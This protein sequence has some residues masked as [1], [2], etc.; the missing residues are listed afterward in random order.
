MP[1]L[2][3][4]C[5]GVWLFAGGSAAS[6]EQN[7]QSPVGWY[8]G[9]W[10]SGMPGLFNWYLSK[11]EFARVYDDFVVP[12]GGWTVT[13]VFSTNNFYNFPAVAK[14]SWEIRRGM[15]NGKSG[16]LVAGGLA[17]AVE[18]TVGTAGRGDGSRS[19][20]ISVDGLHVPLAAGR[21]WVS[22][23]PVGRGQAYICAT[24]GAHATGEPP[25]NNGWALYDTQP[26]MRRFRET[27]DMVA[28][29]AGVGIDFSQGV[30][31][32]K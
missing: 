17:A 8:N 19:V 30:L 7:L 20:R 24:R 32:E 16:R 2:A 4:L 27:Q 9:D 29:Q 21:Y 31:V 28:G 12:S 15:A 14:A 5:A 22:V 10:Q 18:K 25:G 13:G 26:G 23:T 3:L 11:H 6:P 1:A